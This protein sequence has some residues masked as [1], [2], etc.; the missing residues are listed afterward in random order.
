MHLRR[1]VEAISKEIKIGFIDTTNS[2]SKIA[3]NHLLHGPRDPIHLN[4]KGYETFADIINSHL[5]RI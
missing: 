3:N 4:R 5:K 1:A 2:M